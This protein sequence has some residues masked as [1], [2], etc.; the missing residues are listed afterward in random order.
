[1]IQPPVKKEFPCE[2]CGKPVEVLFSGGSTEE[3]IK[4]MRKMHI[5]CITK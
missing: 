3:A 1:M 2:V 5:K 4:G